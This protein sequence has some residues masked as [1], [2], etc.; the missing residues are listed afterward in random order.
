MSMT[1]IRSVNQYRVFNSYQ[2][3]VHRRDI[4]KKQ[5][6]K[7]EFARFDRCGRNA[8]KLVHKHVLPL[9]DG[10]VIGIVQTLPKTA[11]MEHVLT[12][13]HS[14]AFHRAQAD[15]TNIVAIFDFLKSGTTKL[16]QHRLLTFQRPQTVEDG[17]FDFEVDGDV[18]GEEGEV[19]LAQEHQ[20]DRHQ[21]RPTNCVEAEKN[22]RVE[23]F[24]RFQGLD[25]HAHVVRPGDEGVE[26]SGTIVFQPLLQTEH[27][28]HERDG[29]DER[30]GFG[31]LQD[32]LR[33]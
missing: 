22:W 28:E 29:D 26:G 21:H 13:S 31:P 24:Q 20:A 12:G 15:G 30:D 32:D 19:E 1:G 5:S 23:L 3:K 27:Q 10:T 14:G 17:V 25:L 11:G 7:I 16:A 6:N 2:F 18:E 4:D 8:P 33:S 9:A